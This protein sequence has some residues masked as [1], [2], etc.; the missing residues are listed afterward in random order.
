MT[1]KKT[2]PDEVDV[3]VRQISFWYKAKTLAFRLFIF[4][5]VWMAVALIV[6]L[7][8]PHIENNIAAAV[9]IT[10]GPFVFGFLVW[11]PA[12]ARFEYLQSKYSRLM[13]AKRRLNAES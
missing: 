8:I 12:Q 9:V 3:V 13:S 11:M 5:L 2:S 6:A 10:I 4:T 1:N 7:A